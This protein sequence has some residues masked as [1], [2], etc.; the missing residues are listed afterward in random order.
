MKDH[1][2]MGNSFQHCKLSE[3]DEDDDEDPEINKFE[4]SE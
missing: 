1:I 4:D 2:I 3:S